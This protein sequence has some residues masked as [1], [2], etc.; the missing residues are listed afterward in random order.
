MNSLPYFPRFSPKRTLPST[1]LLGRMNNCTGTSRNLRSID[2]FSEHVARFSEHQSFHS[3]TKAAERIERLRQNNFKGPLSDILLL[4][5]EHPEDSV[6]AS[7]KKNRPRQAPLLSSP[8]YRCRSTCRPPS[9]VY[10]IRSP[11]KMAAADDSEGEEK[12]AA[13]RSRRTAALGEEI[14][15]LT[16]EYEGRY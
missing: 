2:L 7:S 13:G 10:A 3:W 4:N 8:S 9:G 5:S 12:R 6:V 15:P 14:E 1:L 11:S 16:F